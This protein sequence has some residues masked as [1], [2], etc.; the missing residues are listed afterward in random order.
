M[1][2][3]L[4]LFVVLIFC[5]SIFAQTEN[6]IKCS[7]N[8]FI[9]GNINEKEIYLCF[10]G[11]DFC[12]G[13]EYI[14]KVLEDKFIK[15]NFFF[16]GD[17]Y[18]KEEFKPTIKKLF[19]N[20]HYLGA[21]SNK[22]LLYCDW[23]K[24][25]STLITHD[26]FVKDLEDNF[27][28]MSKFGIA[29]SDARFFMPPFEWYNEQIVKWTE[30]LGLTLVNFTPG[31]LS[32]SDYKVPGMKNYIGS[33]EIYN[34]IINYESEQNLNGFFLLLHIGTHPDRTDKFYFLLEDLVDELQN[35]GY[36]FKRF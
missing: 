19:E 7:N 32:N 1:T 16:T 25:D 26:E 28:E 23:T 27:H 11:G 20:G 33:N 17:F 15:A 22:H 4:S 8:G 34:S 9:R 2:K 35:R 13:G 10:T 12:D 31:T 14:L 5:S 21:H 29:K 18:R 36:K 6:W 24:R 30:E 3:R